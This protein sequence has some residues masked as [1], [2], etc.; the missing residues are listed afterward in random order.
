MQISRCPAHEMGG[1]RV[2][3]RPR[4]QQT[5]KRSNSTHTPGSRTSFWLCPSAP[6]GQPPTAPVIATLVAQTPILMEST[7]HANLVWCEMKMM[8]NSLVG[9]L[10]LGV[11]CIATAAGPP[12]PIYKVSATRLSN[13]PIID[14]TR[15]PG[16][17][18][19]ARHDAGGR[20]GSMLGH[21]RCSGTLIAAQRHLIPYT[22]C[23]HF[24]DRTIT[25]TLR[26][27]RTTGTII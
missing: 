3:E 23:I 7:F 14:K 11:L 20:S 15:K 25:T 16:S 12:K 2:G 13:E 9:I 21:G 18:I 17:S 19:F 8:E 24:Y 10:I 26:T 22:H 1:G 27:L 5:R 4:R 6:S